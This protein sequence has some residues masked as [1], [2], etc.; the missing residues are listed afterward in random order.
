M[1]ARAGAAA[2]K[3]LTV[4]KGMASAAKNKLGAAKKFVSNNRV[5][6]GMAG[7]TALLE[8]AAVAAALNAAIVG[9]LFRHGLLN[10]TC[11]GP[12]PCPCRPSGP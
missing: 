12:C 2:A 1:R 8:F 6:L 10:R 9:R 4:A 3:M 5:I 7:K 11:L